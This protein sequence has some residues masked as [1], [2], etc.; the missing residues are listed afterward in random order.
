[1]GEHP[2][3]RGDERRHPQ[4][5]EQ[6]RPDV[7]RSQGVHSALS[8]RAESGFGRNRTGPAF[9]GH[10]TGITLPP[11]GAGTNPAA[12]RSGE[13]AHTSRPSHIASDGLDAALGIYLVAYSVVAACF[14]LGLYALLQ[15]SK[16]PNPGTAA[17]NPP[18]GTVV[19]YVAPRH[20]LAPP[21]T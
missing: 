6:Q 14:A 19:S 15:P 4:A 1:P 10:P 5:G 3:E 7:G 16:S 2:D 13:M 20:P 12:R 17:Y 11:A 21:E 9:E 18:P 8:S